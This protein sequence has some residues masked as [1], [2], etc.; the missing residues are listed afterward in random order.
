MTELANRALL[1]SLNI[2][3]WTARKL[4]KRE[5]AEVEA[6]N[7]TVAGAARVTKSLLPMS[8]SLD[9]IHKMTG[10]IRTAYYKNTLPWIDGMG[11]IKT[12]GYLEFT[13]MMGALKAEWDDAVADF[14][15]AYPSLYEDA[16]FLLGSLHKAEDYPD[17]ATIA[18][19]FR[20]D[21]SFY[22]VPSAADWRVDI[23]DSAM[24]KLREQIT[25]KVMESQARAMKE[26]WQRL[27]DV[28]SKAH[29]RLSVPDN[30]FRDS[31][32]ENA[33]ELCAVLP[34]L[35]IADDPDLERLRR[36]LEGSLC[37]YDPDDLRKSDFAR[38]HASD[39]LAEIMS[40]MGGM[41]AVAA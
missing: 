16:K 18:S 1:V 29:E 15:L 5:S 23:A 3:Q 36:E 21:V 39:K 41:Y 33:R 4:D 10:N 20:M 32:I 7:G 27:Y 11:I 34:T 31:L 19:K 30:I 2:S 17:P 26:A 25:E 38:K 14:V 8:A 12:E 28:V 22:P 37:Q 40:K 6:R 24:D 9:R 35:N 13:R